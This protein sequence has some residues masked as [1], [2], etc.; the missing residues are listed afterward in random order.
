MFIVYA[1]NP[2]FLSWDYQCTLSLTDSSMYELIQTVEDYEGYCN[3]GDFILSLLE[4]HHYVGTKVIIYV[5]ED[6][7]G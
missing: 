2:V 7:R 4:N 5:V 6:F 3:Q 1:L